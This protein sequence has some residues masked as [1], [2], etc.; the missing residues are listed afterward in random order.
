MALSLWIEHLKETDPAKAAHKLKKLQ[1]A[2]NGRQIICVSKGVQQDLVTSLHIKPRSIQTI[3][4]PF[5]IDQIKQ[6]S[7][8][9]QPDIKKP[10]IVHI[11]RFDNQQKNQTMLLKAMQQINPNYQLVMLTPECAELKTLIQQ[12]KLDDKIKVIGFKSNPYPWIQHANLLL[13]SSNY[14][15]LPTVLIES[16]ICGT[17]VVSTDCPSGPS[18][19]LV[20]ELSHWLTPVGDAAAFAAKVNEALKTKITIPE[21]LI[22]RFDDKIIAK[23]YLQLSEG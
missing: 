1:K 2:F 16:L 18:E 7:K 10:Y 15:G 4:N 22:T 3:Y 9:Y 11:A 5:A 17:P 6:E 14:E 12:N 13:L 8:A 20:D 23:A 19:I 21:R